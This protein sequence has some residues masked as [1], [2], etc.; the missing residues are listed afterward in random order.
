MIDTR[1]EVIVHLAE[2]GVG[3]ELSDLR[4]E[5]HDL[6][7]AGA[8]TV[9]VD[10]SRVRQLSSATLACL[11]FVHRRCRARGGG[12]V[13]RGGGRAA[14]DLLHRNGL[15]RVFH[16]EERPDS[17]RRLLTTWGTA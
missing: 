6:V 3:E 8:C 7:L 16:V 14:L 13:I 15:H 4:W 5:L 2:R 10:V 1:G 11:L 12:V 17:P 9:V